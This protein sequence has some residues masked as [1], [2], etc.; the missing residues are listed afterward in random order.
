METGALRTRAEMAKAVKKFQRMAHVPVTGELDEKTIA[1]MSKPRCGVADDIGTYFKVTSHTTR[2]KR[3]VL[4]PSKW[5]HKNI[6]Y[7]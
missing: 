1:K 2:Y 7:R 6:T 4:G 3:Y 5:P